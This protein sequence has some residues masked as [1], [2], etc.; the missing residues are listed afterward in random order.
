MIILHRLLLVFLL[1]LGNCFPVAGDDLPSAP[2]RGADEV[3]VAVLS[4]Q[5]RPD[6][7]EQKLRLYLGSLPGID[8][9][10]EPENPD[11]LFVM[12]EKL[13]RDGKKIRYLI[14]A[15]H[16]DANSPNIKF[17]NDSLRAD[18]VDMAKAQDR[19]VHSLQLN[20]RQNRR[21]DHP[22]DQEAQLD[23]DLF[24]DTLRANWRPYHHKLDAV[25]DAMAADGEIL[26]LNCSAAAT[27]AGKTMCRNL[28]QVLL[29]KRGGSVI[30]STVDIKIDQAYTWFSILGSPRTGKWITAGDVWVSGSWIKLDIP[31]RPDPFLFA[32]FHES[33]LKVARAGEVLEISPQVD[34]RH[35]SG[36]L[37]YAWNGGAPSNQASYRLQV[38]DNPEH[39]IDIRVRVQDQKGRVAEDTF[40][41]R[42]EGV[43]IL[44]GDRTLPGVRLPLKSS[45]VPAQKS[46]IYRWSG[47]SGNLGNNA[48][49]SFVS[50]QPGSFRISLEVSNATGRVGSDSKMITVEKA[51][52]TSTPTATV[53]DK[54]GIQVTPTEL[55]ASDFFELSC[56][57]PPALVDKV[58]RFEWLVQVGSGEG[59]PAS[60]E[61]SRVRLQLL[62]QWVGSTFGVRLYDG[63]GIEVAVCWVPMQQIKTRPALFSLSH[64]DSWTVTRGQEGALTLTKKPTLIVQD[65]LQDSDGQASYGGEAGGGRLTVE[66]LGGDELRGLTEAGN[67]PPDWTLKGD[68]KQKGAVAYR[69]T[70]QPTGGFW[71]SSGG[72]SGSQLASRLVEQYQ[73]A[74][75]AHREYAARQAK[76]ML[77]SLRLSPG[78]EITARPDPGP[79]TVATGPS[80]SSQAADK[81]KQARQALAEGRI[82]QAV[83]LGDQAAKLDPKG[84][85]AAVQE[86][87]AELK[88]HGWESAKKQDFGAA[89][90]AL[91]GALKLNPAD[92]DARAKADRLARAEKAW[93]QVQKLGQQ[94]D[95]CLQRRRLVSAYPLLSEM[96]RLSNDLIYSGANMHPYA[97]GV[98][99]RYY[100][101]ENEWNQLFR[102]IREANRKRFQIK[103]YRGV[104]NSLPNLEAWELSE[105]NR[106]AVDNSRQVA[107]RFLDQQQ[108]DWAY[109]ES[110]RGRF[111]GGQLAGAEI[112]PSQQQLRARLAH[113][114]AS[115][116]RY[117]KISQLIED[118]KIQ[119][120][121]V[122]LNG[123]ELR[124]QVGQPITIAARIQ[125]G[126]APYRIQWFDEDRPMTTNL[127]SNDWRFANPGRFVVTALVSDSRQ[128][129]A[130]ANL[131]VLVTP[132]TPATPNRDL[133]S[134]GTS[135]PPGCQGDPF[136]GG[137]WNNARNG[138]DWLQRNFAT[139]RRVAEIRIEQ[140]GTDV[141][142]EGSSIEIQLHIPGG[143]WVQVDRLQNTNINWDRLTGGRPARSIPP[144]RKALPRPVLADGVRLN[145]TGNGWF[146][147][148]NIQV[149]AE[150][151][152]PSTPV[153]P[154]APSRVQQV[155]AVLRNESNQNVHIFTEGD[156]FGPH[157]RLTPGQQREVRLQLPASGRIRF[158]CGRNGQILGA[159][160]WNGDPDHANRYP[161][162]RFTRE[163]TLVILTGLR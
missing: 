134:F 99:R 108:Q 19:L 149:L 59:V 152:T 109:Y 45:V 3:G 65:K 151:S 163:E 89:Q 153:P 104:L 124:G 82:E 8:F 123:S 44:G 114:E 43:C 127:S 78:G 38:K 58:K 87:A 50:A 146:V 117:Q 32:A 18:S 28:G 37:T 52:P 133:T 13:T 70:F 67:L 81:L 158:Q 86:L 103:D 118:L 96:I 47:P 15:G 23:I 60:G 66:W 126:K 55:M 27:P 147:A 145:L 57:L 73:P 159:A 102:D 80:R 97:D 101:R 62:R 148:K 72:P 21:Y 88:N 16:G 105:A 95:E 129:Q 35:D 34:A 131:V 150:S 121:Q 94:V 20:N 90:T 53:V 155:V 2:P 12:L 120:L 54:P 115:D 116:E 31:A 71:P 64:P 40:S 140:A 84:S 144:Y 11:E 29:G 162:V 93:P 17:R 56:Q 10:I 22:Q 42:V 61:T 5:A 85:Q 6:A 136:E 154:V 113:F 4:P 111:D 46:L 128:A 51:N 157:N 100:E 14:I 130:K 69:A 156:H 98:R 110:V 83:E 91:L 143:N 74:I 132:A 1:F 107:Q 122:L 63:R 139:P 33:A 75:Q 36:A 30:A 68:I 39:R 106:V 9:L 24:I 141:T 7:V 112:V 25:S 160:T 135:H 138:G 49:L 77:A 48:D 79:P 161:Q 142:T 26:L 92:R 137:R 76:E 125:G 41:V 119:P